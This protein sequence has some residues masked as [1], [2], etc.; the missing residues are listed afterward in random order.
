[1]QKNHGTEEPLVGSEPKKNYRYKENDPDYKGE[2]MS[3]DLTSGIVQN[4]GCTDILFLILFVGFWV[5]MIIIASMAFKT[6]QPN[7]LASPYDTDGNVCRGKRVF[8][9][10]ERKPL[11]V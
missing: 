9:G 4:R 11:R 5:G 8:K 6:G 7:R 3:E 1:M 10:N 2:P